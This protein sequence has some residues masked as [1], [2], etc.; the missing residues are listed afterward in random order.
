MILVHNSIYS[1]SSTPFHAA[2][3]SVSRALG[4]VRARVRGRS[5]RPAGCRTRALARVRDREKS[6]RSVGVLERED[7]DEGAFFQCLLGRVC[8]GANDDGDG[9]GRDDD[10]DD[11]G[12][13][14]RGGSG[15]GGGAGVGA[16]WIDAAGSGVGVGERRRRGVATERE[17]KVCRRGIRR[18]WVVARFVAV[19]DAG[20]DD[21]DGDDGSPGRWSGDAAEWVRER[22]AA[23]RDAA[24]DRFWVA[25]RL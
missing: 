16:E 9:T 5:R 1:H 4:G 18:R 17:E 7:E 14:T 13:G 23:E 3:P 11:G 25:H 6:S 20:C 10:D 2:V 21:G 15:G 22:V 12:D 24:T 8:S 19:V